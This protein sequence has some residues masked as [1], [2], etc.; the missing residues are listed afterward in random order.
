MALVRHEL[1]GVPGRARDALACLV[2]VNGLGLNTSDRVDRHH[3]LRLAKPQEAP[4]GNLQ[5][6]DLLL[7]VVHQ[8]VLD[9]AELFPGP[10]AHFSATDIVCAIRN[11]EVHVAESVERGL[12]DRL[13]SHMICP[14]C[15]GAVRA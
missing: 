10:I 7:A 5:E 13:R 12:D 8:Q 15:P 4:G 11:R 1:R 3:E 6:S 14:P 9:R 2:N